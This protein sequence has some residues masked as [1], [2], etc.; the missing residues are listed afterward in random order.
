M[1]DTE[2]RQAL[3]DFLRTR[4]ARLQPSDVGLPA[5]T[6]RRTP[7]LRREEVAE[8]ANIGVS[9]YTLLEQGRDIKPSRQVLENLAGVLKLTPAETRHLFY[10]ALQET[11]LIEEEGQMTPALQRVVEA[12]DPN[13]AFVIGRR[14]DVLTWNRAAEL[15]FQFH[16]PCSPHSRNMIWRFFLQEARPHDPDWV[17]LGQNY[18]AGFRA[19]Y[20][21]YPADASFQAL[22]QDLQRFS[23]QFC[24]WWSEQNVRAISD[25]TRTIHDLHLGSLQFD[26]LSFQTPI[27]PDLSLKVFVTLP[28]TGARLAAAL[29]AST[30][31]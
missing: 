10:L 24:I 7:G 18:V 17:R 4:R 27:A 26:H 30:S 25:E 9:W 20:V 21:R 28:E 5:R 8:L 22:L 3:A 31:S 1:N 13:P 14:W 15:L 12:L 29:A 2:R 16:E 6:R 19:S 11:P 23:T